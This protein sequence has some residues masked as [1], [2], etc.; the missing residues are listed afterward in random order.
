MKRRRN[1]QKCGLT[2]H[3]SPHQ[4]LTSPQSQIFQRRTA[5]AK[6]APELK[7]TEPSGVFRLKYHHAALATREFGRTAALSHDTCPNFQ[8]AL[9]WLAETRKHP[10]VAGGV[11][12]S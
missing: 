7:E 2:C 8:L 9:R 11:R 6:E 5:E 4:L 10:I 1:M 3:V 12:P